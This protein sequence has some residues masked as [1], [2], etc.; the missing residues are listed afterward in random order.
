[1]QVSI[2]TQVQD[3]NLARTMVIFSKWTKCASCGALV[4][5]VDPRLNPDAECICG[6]CVRLAPIAG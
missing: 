3:G 1:M 2:G 4:L 5:F 6:A